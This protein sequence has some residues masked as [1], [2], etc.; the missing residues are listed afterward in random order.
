MYKYNLGTHILT[1]F[2]QLFSTFCN[3]Y[4]LAVTNNFLPQ[5]PKSH[6]IPEYIDVLQ[7]DKF[8]IRSRLDLLWNIQPISVF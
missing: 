8:P 2:L 7:I 1:L 5:K 6:S 3:N 4:L